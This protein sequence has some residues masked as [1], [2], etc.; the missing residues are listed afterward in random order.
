M[1]WNEAKITINGQEL[2]L[3]ES[4][5]LRCAVTSFLSDVSKNG[6]GEDETGKAIAE[7]YIRHS[8]EILKK[9][10]VITNEKK[11]E[12]TRIPQKYDIDEHVV[13]QG[14]SSTATGVVKDIQWAYHRRLE[15]YSWHYL[16]GFD[17]GQ[18]NPWA[19]SYIPEGYIRKE[20]STSEE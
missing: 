10:G 14:W 7:S 9:I 13:V 8:T 6:L 11:T 4:M 19:M 20:P 3:A 5:T 15:E 18:I 2:S 16:I 12:H 1:D 17:E